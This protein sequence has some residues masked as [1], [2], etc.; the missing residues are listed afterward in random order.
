MRKVQTN[1]SSVLQTLGWE[2]LQEESL[3]L[4]K[5]KGRIPG[6]QPIYLDRGEFAYKLIMHTHQKI[7]HFGVTNTMAALRE[8]W[9][10]PR[11]RFKVKK[12]I[13]DCNVCKIYGVK[14]CGPTVTAELPD[15]RVESG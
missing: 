3:G 9:W 7:N 10:I 8:D 14:P 5:S 4:L 6:Y 13:N 1:L 15:F 2:V 12:V 11:L